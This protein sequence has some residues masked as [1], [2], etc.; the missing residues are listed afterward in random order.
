MGDDALCVVWIIELLPTHAILRV[1]R[2]GDR[3]VLLTVHLVCNKTQN[4]RNGP[5]LESDDHSIYCLNNHYPALL[6]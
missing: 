1:N 6:L 4:K 3:I 5:L 2:A